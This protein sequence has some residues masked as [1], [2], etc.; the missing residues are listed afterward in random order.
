MFGHLAL[1]EDRGA[2]GIDPGGDIGGGDLAGGVLEL[3]GLAVSGL[4]GDGVHVHHAEQAGHLGLHPHPI[5]QRPQIISQMQGVG[6]LHARKHK[7]FMGGHGPS[8]AGR[9]MPRWA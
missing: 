5:L 9:V 3:L 6:G 4:G 7:R 8:F 1:V 2:L